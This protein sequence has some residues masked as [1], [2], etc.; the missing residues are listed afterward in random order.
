MD[1]VTDLSSFG[2]NLRIAV[3]GAT[4]GLA[5]GFIKALGESSRVDR[6]YALGRRMPDS[7]GEKTVF[8]P[9]DLEEE[10]SVERAAS[11][12]SPKL[13]LVLVA[14]G[15]LH[16]GNLQPEK[17]WRHFSQDLALVNFQINA[18]GPMTVAKHFLPKLHRDRKVVFAALSAKVGSIS[19]NGLG[20][21]YSYRAS[22]AALNQYLKC[23]AIELGRKN[24]RAICV[25]LHPGTVATKLSAPFQSNVAKGKL[26]GAAQAAQQLLTVIDGLTVEQTGNLI[27]WDGSTID[28]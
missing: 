16:Q 21:W 24:D 4:G 3:V 9:L 20:G 27:S 5:Q 26:F 14:T 19:D 1:Q 8:L 28:P 11:E 10:A 17:T 6:I 7:L 13:D 12:I 15:F 18:F 25:G 22:K 23:A 2:E